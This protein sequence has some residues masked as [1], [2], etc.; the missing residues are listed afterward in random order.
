[1]FGID[2]GCRGISLVV[3]AL[4]Q[5]AVLH[6]LCLDIEH[7]TH[8]HLIFIVAENQW[9]EGSHKIS[10]PSA[11]GDILTK[12]HLRR[13][14]CTGYAIVVGHIAHGH[15]HIFWIFH[16]DGVDGVLIVFGQRNGI[17][18]MWQH[19]VDLDL[20]GCQVEEPLLCLC[21]QSKNQQGHPHEKYPNSFIRH[22]LE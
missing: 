13:Q 4:A 6:G 3:L 21:R 17:E 9:T 12:R 2:V 22:I 7:E 15:I 16:R 18:K 14:G 20:V 1:M 8:Q 11:H 10:F 19:R 5:H